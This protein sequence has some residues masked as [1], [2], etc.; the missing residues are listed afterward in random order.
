MHLNLLNLSA[1]RPALILR[2]TQGGPTGSLC[3]GMGSG[4]L[5]CPGRG[6][7]GGQEQSQLLR[8]HKLRPQEEGGR[9]RW[10]GKAR[11]TCSNRRPGRQPGRALSARLT[12]FKDLK[13][14]YKEMVNMYVC[15]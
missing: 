7:R 4:A 13:F 9:P 10:L 8:Q 2:S 14:I 6:W 12:A 3:L 1:A 5:V 11:G 15:F